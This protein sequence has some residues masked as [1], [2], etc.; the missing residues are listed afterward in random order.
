MPVGSL[1]YG[2]AVTPDGKY[3]YVANSMDS[4]VSVIDTTTNTAIATVN[5]GNWPVAFGQ[6]IGEKSVL[7]PLS[8]VS[9][10]RGNVTAG[11]NVE[12]KP[13]KTQSS[14]TS[15]K[16]SI[17]TSGFEIASGITCLFGAFLYKQ[18][19]KR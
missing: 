8:P 14:N 5:V 4:T 2:I 1:P 7:E 6:F 16:G 9:D 11:V 12:Q 15:G 3:V 13:E 19:K 10:L 17:K 18:D